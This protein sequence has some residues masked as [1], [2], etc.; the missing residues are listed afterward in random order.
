MLSRPPHICRQQLAATV[1]SHSFDLVSRS[2]TLDERMSNKLKPAKLPARSST[3]A[4]ARLVSRS[5][6]PPNTFTTSLEGVVRNQLALPNT[7]HI[8]THHAAAEVT[9]LY[10]SHSSRLQN[11]GGTLPTQQRK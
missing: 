5:A 1:C 6:R 7:H 3:R 11:T 8:H 2:H 9:R 10:F 4:R